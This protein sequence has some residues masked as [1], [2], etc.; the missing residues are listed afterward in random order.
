MKHWS[1]LV[2]TVILTVFFSCR[3]DNLETPLF[4]S[5]YEEDSGIEIFNIDKFYFSFD[6]KILYVYFINDSIMLHARELADSLL[7]YRDGEIYITDAP[8]DHFAD[9]NISQDT[10]YTYEFA[11]RDTAGALTKISAEH[12]IDIP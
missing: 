3:K 11:F 6:H 9:L 12:V 8:K 4:D 2:V 5:P 1:L 7:I 10:F